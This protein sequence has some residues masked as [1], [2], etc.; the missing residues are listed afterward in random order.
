MD[1]YE[2]NN[3]EKNEE[4]N[5]FN[6][7]RLEDIL[8]NENSI[9][10]KILDNN[11]HESEYN[12]LPPASVNNSQ[13]ELNENKNN[14]PLLFSN[15][16]ILFN[17]VYNIRNGDSVDLPTSYNP[18]SSDNININIENSNNSIKCLLPLNSIIF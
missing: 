16:C 4:N 3:N 8:N 18:K 2:K 5:N 10:I 13:I 12:S 11:I 6:F 9:I 1:N 15:Y 17:L 14:T 7:S